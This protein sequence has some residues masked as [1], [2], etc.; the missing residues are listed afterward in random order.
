MGFEE[1]IK[2]ADAEK[3]DL[4]H[5][6][7]N[8]ASVFAKQT[9]NLGKG[10]SVCYQWRDIVGRPS[11]EAAATGNGYVKRL[12][13]AIILLLI[14]FRYCVGNGGYHEA[15]DIESIEIED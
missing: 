4:R 11:A 10:I 13:T 5:T 1:S 6:D 7:S 15:V 14:F 9:I 12:I 2:R 3:K 8:G